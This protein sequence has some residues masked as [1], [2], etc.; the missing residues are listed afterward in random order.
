MKIEG[1]A[2]KKR[3]EVLIT[4]RVFFRVLCFV[5]VS[6]VS[7]LVSSGSALTRSSSPLA[8]LS[9]SSNHILFPLLL[10]FTFCLLAFLFWFWLGSVADHR[11][12][13]Y[14]TTGRF[15][16]RK[17][18]NPGLMHSSSPQLSSTSSLH[19]RKTSELGNRLEN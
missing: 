1:M 10:F 7:S 2:V 8:R 12:H 13:T 3:V 5:W 16:R 14:P 11:P 19:Q 17:Y 6:L 15:G 9:S 18:Y 4:W